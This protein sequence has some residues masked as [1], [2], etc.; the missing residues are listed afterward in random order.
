VDLVFD[1]AEPAIPGSIAR[2]RRTNVA[3]QCGPASG[4]D[5]D[6]V[7]RNQNHVRR[8]DAPILV[9]GATGRQGG[10]VA[11]ALW[12][13]DFEVHAPTRDS[14]TEAVRKPAAAGAEVVEGNFDDH[15]S[16]ER[17]A[18]GAIGVFSV[19]RMS[20]ADDPKREIRWGRN[21]AEAAVAAGIGTYVRP[22]VAKAGDERN[23]VGRNEG[24]WRQ[25]YWENKTAVASFCFPRLSTGG[26]TR[27]PPGS[28]SS[29][30]AISELLRSWCSRTRPASA[31]RKFP[32]RATP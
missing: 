14:S 27:P 32:W 18:Q 22:S 3:A 29:P 10:G 5:S 9:A 28:R 24:R 23:F 13:A 8:S 4:I 15:D 20:T 7:K 6:D 21:L 31:V 2:R 25:S 17:A 19:Q 26:S 11:A 12:R 30:R 16:L 1:A